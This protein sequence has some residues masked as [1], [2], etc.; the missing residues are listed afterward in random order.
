MHTRGIAS[1]KREVMFKAAATLGEKHK[2]A[3]VAFAETHGNKLIEAMGAVGMDLE[4]KVWYSYHDY[5]LLC[6]ISLFY[7]C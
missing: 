6:F 5:W 7:V 3:A 4:L 1:E 2:E